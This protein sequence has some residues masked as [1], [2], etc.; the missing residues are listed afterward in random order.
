[1]KCVLLVLVDV[2]VTSAG[3]LLSNEELWTVLWEVA[4]GLQFL[5]GNGVL[6]LDIKPENI[7][8]QAGGRGCGGQGVQQPWQGAGVGR[9]VANAAAVSAGLA[10]RGLPSGATGQLSLC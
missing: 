10:Q 9:V 2:Q 1:M 6:H 7:Y 4:S 8:R 5:H 3:S